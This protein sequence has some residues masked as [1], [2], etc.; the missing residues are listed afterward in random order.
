MW[1][2]NH[3]WSV[4]VL[5]VGDTD[6]DGKAELYSGLEG[7]DNSTII[8][9]GDGESIGTRIY[10]RSYS[11]T[12]S[13]MATGD[14]DGN[15]LDELYVGLRGT[16]GGTSIYSGNGTSIGS[17]FYGKNFYWTINALAAGDVDGDGDDELFLGFNSDGGSAV[18]RTDSDARSMRRI[19]GPTSG[20]DVF[21]LAVY[22]DEY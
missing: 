14:V 17:R 3:D 12:L 4:K 2:S 15:G 6:G 9:R 18:Y 10:G 11:W 7:T 20:M 8:Y 16:D 13:A 19:S 22:D 5:A 21:S 1:K